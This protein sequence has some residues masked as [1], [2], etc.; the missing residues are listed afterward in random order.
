M[1]P[2]GSVSSAQHAV[3]GI[4]GQQRP[5][6]IGSKAPL[7]QPLGRLQRRQAEARRGKR[8]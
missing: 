7:G 4:A 3:R 1:A 8:V 6:P 2:D 5:R